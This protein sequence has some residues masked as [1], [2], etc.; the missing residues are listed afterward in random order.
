[1]IGASAETTERFVLRVAAV[2][3]VN[4]PK[5]DEVEKWAEGRK[6]G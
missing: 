4:G 5:E 6:A 3:T 1:M 2:A